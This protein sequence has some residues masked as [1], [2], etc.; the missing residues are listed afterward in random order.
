MPAEAGAVAWGVERPVLRITRGVGKQ[1]HLALRAAGK[2]AVEAGG[3][4]AGARAGWTTARRS[5]APRRD[6][7]LPRLPA[8]PRRRASRTAEPLI[9]FDRAAGRIAA[10]FSTY[11]AG[12]SGWQYGWGS[13]GFGRIGRNVFRAAKESGADIDWVAV[14]DLTDARTLATS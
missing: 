5:R 6:P 7:V 1:D 3:R 12:G 4:P 2:A 8:R 14:N 9:A 10:A 11:F 13:T